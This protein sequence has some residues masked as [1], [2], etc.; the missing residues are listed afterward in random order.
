[1]SR[2]DE[3]RFI[4]RIAQRYYVDGHRQ[5]AI[6]RDLRMSQATVSRMVRRAH[7]EGIVRISLSAPSGTYPELEAQI[8]Q[9]YQVPEVMVVDCA[10]DNDGAIMARI[11]EAAAHFFETTLQEGEVIGISS[12]S[13]TIL[14]MID[15]I[16][17]MKQTS[18]KLVVQMLGGIGN[19]NVQK[20]ATNLTTRLSQ[21]TGA[22]P[23]ILNAPAVAAS[24][25]AKLVLLG[26]S[27][28]R[29]T[30][31]QFENITLAIV[32]IGAVEP[33]S[34]LAQSGNIFSEAELHQLTEGGAVAEIG[35]QFL[36][37]QGALVVTP[38]T[39]RVIGMRLDQL[40]KVPRVV[41]LA[42]G[43]KKSEAIRAVLKSG[44][45]DVLITDRFTADRL[46]ETEDDG[47]DGTDQQFEETS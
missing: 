46:A 1:L 41:A 38:L 45:V 17:P 37:Q 8:R 47:S 30:M 10:E 29:E 35:Q 7:E 3:L 20:H 12:W 22:E 13:Q 18:A 25:E 34:M 16:H 39:E 19:P 9:R 44:V 43:N 32:G 6:A 21:L 28:V 23:M 15:N 4:A 33:S 2:L 40:Q 36:D 26:D 27:F 42:G 14:K 5:S 31:D 11:G 24:R